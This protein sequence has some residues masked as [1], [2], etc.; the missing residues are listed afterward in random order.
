[1]VNRWKGVW[2]FWHLTTNKRRWYNVVKTLLD[3]HIVLAGLF[4]VE[5]YSFFLHIISSQSKRD[6][7]TML[8]LC[9]VPLIN[10]HSFFMIGSSLLRRLRFY[11]SNCKVM[12]FTRSVS[13]D[14]VQWDSRLFPKRNITRPNVFLLYP[15][16]FTRLRW[17]NMTLIQWKTIHILNQKNK[18]WRW[19]HFIFYP[20]TF[21]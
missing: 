15:I 8:V 6:D 11:P 16:W 2:G 5:R 20:T 17:T 10:M 21:V 9:N 4:L 19:L 12:S 3:Q 7:Y 1:M 14:S 13:K 18:Y